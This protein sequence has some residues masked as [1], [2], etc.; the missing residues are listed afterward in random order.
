[1]SEELPLSKSDVVYRH[2]MV[3]HLSDYLGAVAFAMII[4]AAYPNEEDRDAVVEIIFNRW[5]RN[6]KLS[7]QAI[8]PN[9]FDIKE[10]DSE[11]IQRILKHLDVTTDPQFDDAV[12][13]ARETMMAVIKSFM[14]GEE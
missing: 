12:S 2:N 14:K 7:R 5:L 13:Y 4:K 1:M 9:Q 6:V 11:D 8:K 3:Q 10:N